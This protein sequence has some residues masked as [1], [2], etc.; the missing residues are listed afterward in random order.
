MPRSPT[1]DDA[2]Q[3]ESLA[4]LVH[5]VGHGRGVT[6]VARIDLDGHG[7]AGLIG[8][9]SVEDHGQLLAVA[10]M[11]EASQGTGLA[12]VVAGARVIQHEPAVLQVTSGQLGFYARLSRQEPVE[13]GVELI[14]LGILHPEL[15]GQG[16]GVPEPGGG[17]LRAGFDEP[18]RDHGQHE[19]AFTA[20]LGRDQRRDSELAHGAQDGFHMAMWARAGNGEGVLGADEPFPWRR[21]RRARSSLRAIRIR[22][23]RLRILPASARPRAGEWLGVSCGWVPAQRTW[24]NYINTLAIVNHNRTDYMGTFVT[25]YF[26]PNALRTVTSPGDKVVFEW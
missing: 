10:V 21:R 5:L 15:L 18:L 12:F 17:E 22:E 9:Q 3:A 6:R 23:V 13:G 7:P 24:H 16:G 2:G 25:R 26:E 11:P 4:Q 14:D 8:E 19:F 20:G 1:E